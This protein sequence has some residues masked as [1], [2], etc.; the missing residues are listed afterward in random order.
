ML[1][2]IER[3]FTYF[4]SRTHDSKSVRKSH[5]E[6]WRHKENVR[7]YYLLLIEFGEVQLTPEA[8]GKIHFLSTVALN[9]T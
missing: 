3:N 7:N 6:G 1:V 4:F 9:L 2:I 8:Y 5:N